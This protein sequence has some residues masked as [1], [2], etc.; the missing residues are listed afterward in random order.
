MSTCSRRYDAWHDDVLACGSVGGVG[1]VGGVV[2][3]WEA[4]LVVAVVLLLM[5]CPILLCRCAKVWL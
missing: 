5:L 3:V 1:N 4:C 2:V